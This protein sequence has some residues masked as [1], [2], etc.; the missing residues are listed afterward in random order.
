MTVLNNVIAGVVQGDDLEV[1]RTVP[2]LPSGQTATEAWF[3]L[4]ADPSAIDPGVLQKVI[5]TSN[6]PGTGQI[7]KDG[8]V[9]N[10]NGVCELRFDLTAANTAALTAGLTY[11]Y[12]VQVKTSAGKIY[13]A[14]TGTIVLNRQITLSTS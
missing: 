14:E 12:D 9:G 13:T 5:T 4:K 2:G 1:R 10:G 8:S 7:E 11:Y 6:N 3:T